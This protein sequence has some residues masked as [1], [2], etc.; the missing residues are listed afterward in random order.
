VL[1]EQHTSGKRKRFLQ[2]KLEICDVAI[3]HMVRALR[4]S[5]GHDVALPLL[6]HLDGT[7][8]APIRV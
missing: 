7:V 4:P 5:T 6:L 8:A 1:Q 3:P 2:K